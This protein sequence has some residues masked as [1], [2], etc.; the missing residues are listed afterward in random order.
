MP[1]KGHFC[2]PQCTDDVICS[3]LTWALQ[4]S[5][6]LLDGNLRSYH[7]FI[8]IWAVSGL[9]DL[10]FARDG[11]LC[12]SFCTWENFPGFKSCVVLMSSPVSYI[13][14]TFNLAQ[15]KRGNSN[16]ALAQMLCDR[17]CKWWRQSQVRWVPW[18]FGKSMPDLTKDSHS[19]VS[20]DCCHTEM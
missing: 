14:N 2:S 18:H 17:H 15:V 1:G 6:V 10:W 8:S 9:L 7:M 11:F 13:H 12:G 4:P 3:V 20:A 19:L 5:R 16:E